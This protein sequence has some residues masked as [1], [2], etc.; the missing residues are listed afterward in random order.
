MFE[1][2]KLCNAF[3]KLSPVERGAILAE[4]SV[5]V[6]AKLKLLGAEEGDPTFAL[7]SFILGSIVA[8]GKVDEREYLLM[9]P[10]LIQVFGDK[11]DFASV[12]AAIEGDSEGKKAIKA[13]TEELMRDLSEAD[14]S[15][16]EDVVVICLCVVAMDGRVSLKEKNYIKRL[17]KA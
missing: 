17:C 1:F 13:Y 4:K 16:V 2:T 15:L 10:A 8:D 14:E 5:K 3:E 6:L 7:A 12:K 11:F 9:Y